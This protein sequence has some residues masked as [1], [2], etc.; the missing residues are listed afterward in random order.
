MQLTV[1][2]VAWTGSYRI[3][4]RLMLAQRSW[5]GS[6]SQTSRPP[7]AYPLGVPATPELVTSMRKVATEPERTREPSTFEF[8]AF[9]PLAGTLTRSTPFTTVT[10]GTGAADATTV[11][12]SVVEIPAE[13]SARNFIRFD[14]AR[15]VVPGAALV[16]F[17]WMTAANCAPGATKRLPPSPTVPIVNCTAEKA[18]TTVNGAL[19]FELAAVAEPET[20]VVPAGRKS[21]TSGLRVSVRSEKLTVS[22]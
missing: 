19:R 14:F 10:G 20:Y 18:A 17:A 16:T 9:G 21:V 6:L 13:F 7:T 22:A 4:A 12:R 1:G 3:V 11:S 8:A 2:A 5:T 15:V